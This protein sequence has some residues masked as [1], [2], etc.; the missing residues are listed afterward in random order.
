ML[1]L[2]KRTVA[3]PDWAERPCEQEALVQTRGAEMG[4]GQD[5]IPSGVAS[6]PQERGRTQPGSCA[7]LA[8]SPGLWEIAV[9][10]KLFLFK[11]RTA[12]YNS[13]TSTLSQLCLKG[14]STS[15]P[16]HW[17]IDSNERRP[18]WAGAS[19]P[20]PCCVTLATLRWASAALSEEWQ[21]SPR[22]PLSDFI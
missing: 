1:P 3:G 18:A 11:L 21:V 13:V 14:V 8:A 9:G 19:L 7:L 10:R 20:S 12:C 5:G 16:L 2:P 6:L 4:V 17:E 15:L 22:M